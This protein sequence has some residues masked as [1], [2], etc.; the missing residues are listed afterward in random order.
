ME[1]ACPFVRLWKIEG[2]IMANVHITTYLIPF[3]L[4]KKKH[5]L[6]NTWFIDNYLYYFFFFSF[7][8]WP[9]F[10]HQDT[11]SIK[12]QQSPYAWFAKCLLIFTPTNSPCLGGEISEDHLEAKS[13]TL[14]RTHKRISLAFRES[15]SFNRLHRWSKILLQATAYAVLALWGP[16]RT[17]LI[18]PTL[19]TLFSC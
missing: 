2:L 7:S 15:K 13:P 9:P 19:L 14:Y 18:S 4:K 10:D 5:H 16:L 17:T 11:I 6:P 8:I 1:D 12:N 3:Y